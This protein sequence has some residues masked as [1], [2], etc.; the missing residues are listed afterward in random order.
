[1]YCKTKG[2]VLNSFNYSDKSL[3]VKV[4]TELFGLRSYIVDRTKNR[5]SK[6][7]I[8][9]FQPLSLVEMIVLQKERKQLQRIKEIKIDVPFNSITGNILKNSMALFIN[10]ILYKSLSEEEPDQKMFGFLRNS[11]IYLDGKANN[12]VNFHLI[13][14]IQLSKYLGFFPRYNNSNDS[15]YFDLREGV[16]Q[17]NEP[18]HTYYFSKELTKYFYELISFTYDS[19][20]DIHISNEIRR[21]LLRGLI[22]YYE[23]HSNTVREVKS[24]QVLE[25]VIS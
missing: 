12:F 21:E 9:L 1:M 25:E 13:F 2:I 24:H 3:I 10:E 16:F 19:S 6:V 15:H 14:L 20:S 18:N 4:Y 17:K 23:L 8:N 5:K 11:L 22:Q 7:K